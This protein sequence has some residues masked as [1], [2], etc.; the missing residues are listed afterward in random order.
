MQTATSNGTT[1]AGTTGGASTGGT[2]TGGAAI[3]KPSIG[4]PDATIP[5][6]CEVDIDFGDVLIGLVDTIQVSVDNIGTAVLDLSPIDPTLTPAFT[7][8]H[9]TPAPIQPSGSRPVQPELHP[10]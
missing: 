5:N 7:V 1:G 10:S 4:A 9:P 3:G 2:S 8:I 6:P